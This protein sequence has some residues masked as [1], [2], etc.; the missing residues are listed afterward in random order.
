MKKSKTSPETP[1]RTLIMSAMRRRL[2]ERER[3]FEYQQITEEHIIANRDIY[4]KLIGYVD[5]FW[6]KEIHSITRSELN[7]AQQ[8]EYKTFKKRWIILRNE[9]NWYDRE[10]RMRTNDYFNTLGKTLHSRWGKYQLSGNMGFVFEDK[11]GVIEK[12]NQCKIPTKYQDL[13]FELVYFFCLFS[14]KL[15]EITNLCLEVKHF[16][17]L[18]SE[19]SIRLEEYVKA[20][21]RKKNDRENY[22]PL[23]QIV[24]AK[25]LREAA[26]KYAANRVSYMKAIGQE[27]QIQKK[28]YL[29]DIESFERKIQRW[30]ASFK[31]KNAPKPPPFYTRYMT[32]AEFKGWAEA[33]ERERYTTWIARREKKKNRLY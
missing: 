26:K 18:E 29:P 32:P 23:S 19:A 27:H 13:F 17:N 11:Y 24:C 28:G 30:D 20:L 9:L 5:S 25:Y 3:S 4:I 12:P 7:K 15:S 16:F 2:Q 8:K 33:Y 21:K 14:L 31:G 1:D 6:D 22:K 10:I